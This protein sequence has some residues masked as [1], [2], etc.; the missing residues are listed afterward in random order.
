MDV[1]RRIDLNSHI[2]IC[3][4]DD[5][6]GYVEDT[7]LFNEVL[8]SHSQSFDNNTMSIDHT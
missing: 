8:R 4:K 5:G 2:L 6:W 1:N 3:L 7:N